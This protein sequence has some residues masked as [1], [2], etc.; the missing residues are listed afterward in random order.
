MCRWASHWAPAG[1]TNVCLNMKLF[2]KF[3]WYLIQETFV[4]DLGPSINCKSQIVWDVSRCLAIGNHDWF[5]LI[6][7]QTLSAYICFGSNPKTAYDS[8]VTQESGGMIVVFDLAVFLFKVQ[9]IYSAGCMNSASPSHSYLL[10]CSDTSWL[11]DCLTS[12]RN[13]FSGHHC[14][15]GTTDGGLG[16]DQC[17]TTTVRLRWGRRGCPGGSGLPQCPA[18]SWLQVCTEQDRRHQDLYWSKSAGVE[19]VWLQ[20]KNFYTDSYSFSS[21]VV[22]LWVRNM[23]CRILITQDHIIWKIKLWT[24]MCNLFEHDIDTTLNNENKEIKSHKNMPS[25]KNVVKTA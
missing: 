8:H 19:F 15:S 16:S 5:R 6:P 3:V 4:S 11:L 12:H 24:V 2:T 20:T 7:R 22:Q 17:G 23:G 13:E 14:G 21:P 1:Y 25:L 18:H 10:D 9:D